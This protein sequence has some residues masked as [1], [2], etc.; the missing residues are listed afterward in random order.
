M[1]L[2]AGSNDAS[3]LLAGRRMSR[4]AQWWE[5]SRTRLLWEKCPNKASNTFLGPHTPNTAFRHLPPNS[6][7]FSYWAIEGALLISAQ[8]SSD[9]VNALWK[10]RV[11]IWLYMVA[12]THTPSIAF[13]HWRNRDVVNQ[14][15]AGVQRK[16]PSRAKGN[17]RKHETHPPRVKKEE[18]EFRLD[19][20]DCG[21]ICAGVNFGR[22]V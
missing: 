22:L 1:V 10:V 14:C 19:S 17:A 12:S 15:L 16:Q 3:S 6:A 4:A 8:L 13:Q 9:A 11:L 7:R 18:K 2:N 20:N 21:F 5:Q